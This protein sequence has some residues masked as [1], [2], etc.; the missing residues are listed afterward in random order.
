MGFSQDYLS[1]SESSDDDEFKYF[2]P[3]YVRRRSEKHHTPPEGKGQNA[4]CSDS[5]KAGDCQKAP[6]IQS[7]QPRPGLYNLKDP[8]TGAFLKKEELPALGHKRTPPDRPSSQQQKR[9]HTKISGPTYEYGDPIN[10]YQ[11]VG[12]RNDYEKFIRAG[13]SSSSSAGEDDTNYIDSRIFDRVS[14]HSKRYSRSDDIAIYWALEPGATRAPLPGAPHVEDVPIQNIDKASLADFLEKSALTLRL[15]LRDVLKQQRVAWHPDKVFRGSARA[16][17]NTTEK[18]T[19][20][21]QVI[22]SLWEE[23]Q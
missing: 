7:P 6:A 16:N 15:P 4:V 19:R 2:K 22:N 8:G 13:K 1:A 10:G 5:A 3:V 12:S 21:F 14:V 17:A 20:I 9:S 18:V 23:N 11:F